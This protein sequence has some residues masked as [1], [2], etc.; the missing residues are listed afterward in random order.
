MSVIP[1]VVEECQMRAFSTVYRLL[2]KLYPAYFRAQFGDEMEGVFVALLKEKAQQGKWACWL[3]F[4]KEIVGLSIAVVGEYLKMKGVS[5]MKKLIGIGLLLYFAA[6]V[7]VAIGLLD[8]APA[9]IHQVIRE[10]EI[11]QYDGETGMVRLSG[12]H[13]HCSQRDQSD[14]STCSME[15]AGKPLEIYARRTSPVSV[16]FERRLEGTCQA[17]YDGQKWP[18]RAGNGLVW[19]AQIPEP[20]GLDRVGID[21]LRQNYWIENL[22]EAVFLKGMLVLSLATTL[23]VMLVLASYSQQVSMGNGH[24]SDGSDIT[25]WKPCGMGLSGRQ[26]C[27]LA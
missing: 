23:V 17:Y 9:P 22:P 16:P 14:G 19:T 10:V 15:L 3:V 2:L 21:L 13:L 24:S 27:G 11:G 12:R 18:C 26:F 20:L 7:V 4:V 6:L 8:A 5:R 25:V 1:V